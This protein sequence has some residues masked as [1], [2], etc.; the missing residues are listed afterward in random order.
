MNTLLSQLPRKEP[1]AQKGIA[2][3]IFSGWA[4][5]VSY[6]PSGILYFYFGSAVYLRDLALFAH[7]LASILWLYR[8]GDLR[9][10]LR[11]S[12]VLLLLPIFLIPAIADPEYRFEALRTVKWTL[13]WLDWIFI[14]HFAFQLRRWDKWILIFIAG[15]AAELLLEWAVGFHEWRAGHFLFSTP[16][17]WDEKTVFGVQ[18]V[19][20]E[21]LGGAIRVR[22]FQR[23]VFSFANLMAMSS[24]I[25]LSFASISAAAWQK[26][27]GFAWAAFFAIML[28]VSGGRSA[29]FGIF[30]S[31]ILAGVYAVQPHFARRW[32]KVYVLVWVLIAVTISFSGVGDLTDTISG[33]FLGKSHIGDS[34]SA[35]MRDENWRN[36]LDAFEN[37]PVILMIGGP[38]SSLMESRVAPMFHWADNQF[39]WDTYHLGLAG[40]LA[41]GFYFFRVIRMGRAARRP[42]A[43]DVLYICLLLVMG[44]GIAR[45]S[46]TFMGCMPLFIVCG[47]VSAAAAASSVEAGEEEEPHSRSHSRRKRR[48]I[49]EASSRLRT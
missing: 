12:A 47:Y 23:D 41:I 24:V 39:L 37:Y 10:V 19:K 40:S 43:M 2:L 5:T 34:Y 30:A 38:F 11:Q 42:I 21:T 17:T 1:M 14:G 13:F 49:V 27:A 15:T 36:M 7:L 4:I 9:W 8:I 18:A 48:R 29:L 46:L 31:T 45:E 32:A 35:Y 28:V 44:E 26:A 20:E 6:F 16:T 25:G 3:L 22:G 33:A